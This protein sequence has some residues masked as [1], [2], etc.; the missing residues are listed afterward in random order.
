M[1]CLGIKG[2]RRGKV[3]FW[4]HEDEFDDNGEGRQDYGNVYLLANSLD[5]FL[6][7]LHENTEE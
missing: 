4:D 7:K 5:E 6:N 2:K 1:I 3:Y